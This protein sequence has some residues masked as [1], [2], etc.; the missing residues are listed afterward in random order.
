MGIEIP[1]HGSPGLCLGYVDP[2]G[3]PHGY[4]YG[5]GIGWKFRTHGS[6][7]ARGAHAG[8]DSKMLRCL[9]EAL[10]S[11]TDRATRRVSENLANCCTAV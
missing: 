8:L 1:S 4:G 5:V 10:L 3:D 7:E 9:Q 2:R 6:S 11:Q